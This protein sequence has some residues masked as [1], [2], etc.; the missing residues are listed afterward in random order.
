MRTQ[1]MI[2]RMYGQVED[3]GSYLVYRTPSVPDYWYGNCLLMPATPK[4]SD[5]D[6]WM[7]LFAKEFPDKTHRVFQ[8]DSADG[9]SGDGAAFLAAGFEF[10]QHE[11][12]AADTIHQPERLNQN[13]PC[14]PARSDA[15]WTS[16]IDT[17]YLTNEGRPGFDRGF[18]ERK[19]AAVRRVC[20]AGQGAW[21][22]SWEG[23]LNTSH[24]GL[25]WQDGLVRFQD[26]ATHPDYRRQGLCRTLLYRAC[27][28]LLARLGPQRFVIMPEDESVSRIYQSVGFA[29]AEYSVDYCRRPEG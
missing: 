21:W 20:E 27:S 11:V 9:Q 13:Q 4:A 22:G 14:R 24:M 2:Q 17:A 5:F 6:H 3:R 12:L 8:I 16:I 29:F 1:T 7:Q 10:S 23:E 26:V 19:F 28:E 25:F 18:L 15:D